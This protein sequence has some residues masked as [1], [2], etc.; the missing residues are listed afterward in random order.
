MLEQ[1][2]AAPPI[3]GLVGLAIA[4]FIYTVMSRREV[5]EGNV[6]KIGDQIHLGAMVFMK[7]EYTYLAAFAGV[8]LVLILISDLD[9]D[10]ALS[11]V[12]GAS[13]S[14]LAG[15]LG[16]YAATKANVRTAIA[17]NTEGAPAALS[18]AFYG[19]SIMGLCVASLGLIGLGSLYFYFGGDPKAA[20]AIHGFGMGGS[21]VALFSRVG[22]GIY[23]KSADVGAD[24]VGK[25]EAGIP[26]DDPR[27]PG[28]IA[29][30]VGDNVGDIAGMGSDIFESYCGSMIACMAIASTMAIA[31]EEMAGMMFLPLALASVG[32]LS[33][34]VGILIV[35]SRSAS[36]DS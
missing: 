36:A 21:V 32:L 35:R 9:N 22:G 4:F 3:L 34:V 16:M 2:Y 28:V 10:T 14:A 15:W 25:V 6:K 1:L 7:R 30:N 17:A 20:H 19:G 12:V 8:L 26:E 18:V 13:S 11:F 27:N 23:T 33:S 5:P 24:L 29:D 31:Q